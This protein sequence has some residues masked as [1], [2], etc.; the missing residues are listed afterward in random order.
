MMD[1]YFIGLLVLSLLKLS[2]G[3][4]LGSECK[5]IFHS[6]SILL[7]KILKYVLFIRILVMQPNGRLYKMQND[8]IEI[9]CTLTNQ[10]YYT[11]DDLI[12]DLPKPEDNNARLNEIKY[13]ESISRTEVRI[14]KSIFLFE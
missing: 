5:F 4:G 14:L 9:T 13:I 7:N 6:I 8:T 3:D 2:V 11:I 10:S 12:F 1:S